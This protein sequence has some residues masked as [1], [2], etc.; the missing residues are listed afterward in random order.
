[1]TANWM[2]K[3]RYHQLHPRC[4]F[5]WSFIAIAPSVTVS[6]GADITRV[7]V[8]LS[9]GTCREPRRTGPRHSSEFK[10]HADRRVHIRCVQRI[11]GGKTVEHPRVHDARVAVEALGKAIVGIER[12]CIFRA[13]AA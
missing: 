9:R 7:G 5:D 3:S 6:G 10:P 11:S 4:L 8:R 1:M 2:T 12:K 13:A